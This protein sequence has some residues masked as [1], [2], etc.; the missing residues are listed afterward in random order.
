MVQ[1]HC[2]A[3]AQVEQT[4]KK[5]ICI[6]RFSPLKRQIDSNMNLHCCREPAKVLAAVPL[7]VPLDRIES[8]SNG[9]GVHDESNMMDYIKDL[10][11]NVVA[12][13][14]RASND[15]KEYKY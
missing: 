9:D 12:K 6:E 13:I 2:G 10:V 14:G 11:G 7:I 3:I 15:E 5:W 8:V 1:T 4:E